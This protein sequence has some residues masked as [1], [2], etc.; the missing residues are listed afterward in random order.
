MTLEF[1]P[2]I[3]FTW[4]PQPVWLFQ[5]MARRWCWWAARSSPFP[6]TSSFTPRLATCCRSMETLRMTSCR[7]NSSSLWMRPPVCGITYSHH[8]F[9]ES[10][11]LNIFFS[12]ADSSGKLRYE[13]LRICNIDW[14]F[15]FEFGINFFL[16]FYI[17]FFTCWVCISI[18]ILYRFRWMISSNIEVCNLFQARHI[19]ARIG[20]FPTCHTRSTQIRGPPSQPN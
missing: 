18:E 1:E 11:E 3:S 2:R 20:S 8:Y 19:A 6:P 4:M 5:M 17:F 10:N 15:S 9:H 12:L 13:N 16:Y 7:P 14:L